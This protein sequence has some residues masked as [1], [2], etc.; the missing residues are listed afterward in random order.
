MCCLAGHIKKDLQSKRSVDSLLTVCW[1]NFNVVKKEST[2]PGAYTYTIFD[3]NN[4][5]IVRSGKACPVTIGR[6]FYNDHFNEAKKSDKGFYGKYPLKSNPKIR[7]GL[8]RGWMNELLLFCAL[9]FES[10]NTTSL[11]DTSKEGIFDWDKSA[12]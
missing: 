9:G 11:V 6:R 7:E 10:D 4:G 8:R 1:S 12:M 2:L 3:P 5:A